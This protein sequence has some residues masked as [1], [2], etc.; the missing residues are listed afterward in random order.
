MK[1]QKVIKIQYECDI[2][3]N[4]TCLITEITSIREI[5]FTNK[6]EA[7]HFIGECT[8]CSHNIKDIY[9]ELY[10]WENNIDDDIKCSNE[11]L[12]EFISFKSNNKN[13]L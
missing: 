6:M 7:L 10:W 12:E 3:G 5:L 2:E 4:H 9:P 13:L 1:D 11:D 8:S